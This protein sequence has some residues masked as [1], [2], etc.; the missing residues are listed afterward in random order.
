[1]IQIEIENS[2]VTAEH[3]K[4]GVQAQN[5]KTITIMKTYASGKP[6]G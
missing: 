5:K 1:M 3:L 6:E 4:I 2:S